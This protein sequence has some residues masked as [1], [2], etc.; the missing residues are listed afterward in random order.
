[1]GAVHG[2]HMKYAAMSAASA[3]GAIRVGGQPYEETPSST[4]YLIVLLWYS[5]L[6]HALIT[7]LFL[8]QRGEWL[9]GK[10][11]ADGSIPLWSLAIWWCFH[12]P[13]WLYTFVHTLTTEAPLA[14]EVQPGWWIGGRYAHYLPGQ[15][16]WSLTID[17]TVEFPEGCIKTSND[18]LLVAVWDGTPPDAHGLEN[19]ARK[20]ADAIQRGDVMVH[21]AHGKGRSTCVMCACL[22]RAGLYATWEEAYEACRK[23][24]KG[25]KLNGKMRKALTSWAKTYP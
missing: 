15:R 3:Y 8:M 22:V 5:A 18:Y 14:S 6:V 13:T 9:I 16:R 11:P 7:S 25:V 2:V 24:R 1:M 4:W 17:L 21:C 20:A 12:L 19:A 23:G 10:R